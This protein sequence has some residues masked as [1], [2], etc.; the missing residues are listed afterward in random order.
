M[1]AKRG[2]FYASLNLA[3]PVFAEET[4]SL[5][6]GAVVTAVIGRLGP[7][8]LTAFTLAG[9]VQSSALAIIGV[10]GTGAAVLAAR[11]LG[12]GNLGLLRQITG[13]TLA[14]GLVA[15][16]VLAIAGTKAAGYLPLVLDTDRGVALLAGE[17]LGPLILFAPPMLMAWLGKSVLRGMGE[18]RLA[19]VIS[20]VNNTVTLVATLVLIGAH[21]TGPAVFGAV[22]GAGLGSLASAASALVI[23]CCHRHLRLRPHHLYL[24]NPTIVAR[25]LRISLPVAW[26]QV[27][28]QLGFT[29]YSFEL[30]NVGVK[31]FAGNQIAQQLEG[32]PLIIGIGFSAAVLTAVGQSLG[33]NLPRVAEQ[34]TRFTA[35]LTIVAMT[36][37]CA[38]LSLVSEPLNRLFT[39]D[40]D[41]IA[42]S[43]VCI[44]LAILEQPGMATTLILGNALRGGGDTRWPAYSTMVGMWL[45]RIP[46]TYL[47][48]TDQGSSIAVAW[49]ITA[50][51]H[52][53]RAAIL[54]LR[55]T[56]CS[57][58]NP[59]PSWP[60]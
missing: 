54:A 19:F 57:W 60:G 5:L 8:E 17:L 41:V 30:V 16:A 26:E 43:A 36:V 21:F 40:P 46:L 28:L 29:L 38:V 33:R 4:Y 10:I 32:I 48:I 24:I 35:A 45:V 42:W 18:T 9:L 56:R 15:G 47:F 58:N 7:D 2:L 39:A 49:L 37:V 11:E 50:G 27:A 14:L 20:A 23:L 25:I 59:R 31:Q 52:F 12:A 6:L 3:G 22:W 34:F 1:A 53:V 51:D 13:H 44:K 55:F